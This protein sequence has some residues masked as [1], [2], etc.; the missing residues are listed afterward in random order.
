MFHFKEN[1]GRPAVYDYPGWFRSF[2][3]GATY[4]Q[5]YGFER[6]IHIESDAYLI[7]SRIQQYCNEVDDGWVTFLGPRHDYPETGIQV[8]AGRGLS[9]FYTVAVQP[10]EDFAGKPI[11]VMLPFTKVERTFLGDRFGRVLTY[12]PAGSRLD[13]ADLHASGSL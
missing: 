1:L 13:H 7:S 4:A 3:F 10:Y 8:I 11:E 5:A 2:A 6:I 9:L 12:V